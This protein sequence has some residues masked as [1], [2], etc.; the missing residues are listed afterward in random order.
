MQVLGSSTATKRAT[1][2]G[3]VLSPG[4]GG[5]EGGAHAADRAEAEDAGVLHHEAAA[6]EDHLDRATPGE[7]APLPPR[8]EIVPRPD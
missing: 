7:P 2:L 1:N 4:W 6:L 3:R 8:A 5:H